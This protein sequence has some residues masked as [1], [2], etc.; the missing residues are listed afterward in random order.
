MIREPMIAPSGMWLTDGTL[1]A[2]KVF[3]E[4]G[5]NADEF[6]LIS[7]EE[8]RNLIQQEVNADGGSEA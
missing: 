4:V 6:Y 5:R 1:Y 3:L 2:K 8:Y 7:D